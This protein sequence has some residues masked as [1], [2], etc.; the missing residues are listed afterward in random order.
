MKNISQFDML[1]MGAKE[2]FGRS[3]LLEGIDENLYTL[4]S[5]IAGKK[6]IIYSESS[7][8][9]L[10]KSYS[11]KSIDELI[12]MVSEDMFNQNVV[13]IRTVLLFILNDRT[14]D[15]LND[16]GQYMYMINESEEKFD[17]FEKER[18]FSD[19]IVES[20]YSKL[21]ERLKTNF[22]LLSVSMMLQCPEI[23]FNNS[24]RCR[25]GVALMELMMMQLKDSDNS[26]DI[27]I[28][29]IYSCVEFSEYIIKN[30]GYGLE[31]DLNLVKQIK[32]EGLSR[33]E[34]YVDRVGD[35]IL[36][37]KHPVLYF[38]IIQL[39]EKFSIDFYDQYM[40]LKNIV[41]L[42]NVEIDSITA[43]KLYEELK[44]SEL[45]GKI[46]AFLCM[47][48]SD[49]EEERNYVRYMMLRDEVEYLYVFVENEQLEK[50]NAALERAEENTLSDS[51]VIDVD[52][53]TIDDKECDNQEKCVQDKSDD[54]ALACS[55]EENVPKDQSNENLNSLLE[56]IST[57]L[58]EHIEDK[59][60]MLVE[61]TLAVNS[62]ILEVNR[63]CKIYIEKY[64]NS[65]VILVNDAN[66]I[67][68]TSEIF[69]NEHHIIN[70]IDTSITQVIEMSKYDVKLPEDELKDIIAEELKD[71][72]ESLERFPKMGMIDS[73]VNAIFNNI[74]EVI[75]NDVKLEDIDIEL[76]D[77]SNKSEDG[78]SL[79]N[80]ESSSVS[81]CIN[82][83]PID[84]F[85]TM[86]DMND[87]FNLFESNQLVKIF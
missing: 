71:E 52:Y 64:S 43:N 14:R 45:T 47:L 80:V 67:T 25:E 31:E 38:M 87:A 57:L 48:V 20:F 24:E 55:E 86:I 77:G 50:M 40:W 33:F 70:M 69:S 54:R 60:N 74:N 49:K 61:K 13:D 12:S 72:E 16:H 6:S 26:F 79:L 5:A 68:V 46:V 75:K 28:N 15:I 73:E 63:V 59:F 19:D 41:K 34:S 3:F 62:V 18:L 22:D 37:E 9:D 21:M 83:A 8:A 66:N 81:G 11:V 4:M 44:I 76:V 51:Q 58:K 65:C 85:D 27:Y 2:Y 35:E 23:Y 39:V 36:N 78:L 10:R 82:Q 7:V 42:K 53:K 17:S 32:I 29:G 30:K 84:S 1:H 56:N